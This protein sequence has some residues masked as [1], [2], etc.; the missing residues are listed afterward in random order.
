MKSFSTIFKAGQ[1]L[2]ANVIPALRAMYPALRFIVRIGIVTSPFYQLICIGS[3][4]Q[5]APNDAASRKA[6][7]VMDRIGRGLLKQD[8]GD[9]SSHRKDVLSVLA[10]ANSME[11]KAHQMK[12]EDVVSR[13][14]QL[15]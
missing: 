4:R 14:Y 7:T 8:K 13:A 10:Q 1:K 3:P 2:S 6:F 5:P 15:F 12:D 9:N 11:E